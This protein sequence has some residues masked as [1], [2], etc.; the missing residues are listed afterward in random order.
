MR[1]AA[2]DSLVASADLNL[3]LLRHLVRYLTDHYTAREVEAIAEAAGI[4]VADLVSGSAWVSLDQFETVLACARGL[5]ANDATFT[6]ACAYGLD[7]V[8]S[9]IRLLLSA[10]S[11][12]SA[13]LAAG[14]NMGLISQISVFEPEVMSRNRVRIGYRTT[15]HES[16]LMCL[17]RQAQIRGLPTL[18][19]LPPAHVVETACVARGDDCCAY[20]V[21][22]Y[23]GRCWTPLAI[24]TALALAFGAVLD[25]VLSAPIQWWWV[26]LFGVVLGHFYELRRTSAANRRIQAEISSACLEIAL[27]E[28]NARRE[29]FT[30]ARRQRMWGDLVQEDVIGRKDALLRLTDELSELG[31]K[32][33]PSQP[34]ARIRSQVNKLRESGLAGQEEGR[35]SLSV[36]DAGLDEL[37]RRLTRAARLATHASGGS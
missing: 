12:V 14:R 27:A 11:P 37:D 19:A 2:K 10:V 28:A 33:D 34:T 3:R 29:L 24:G 7:R 31:R 13:Y 15:K 5:M 30:V 6:N 8:S 25:F 18:W 22:L 9:P 32:R 17:S 26:G 16:R 23:E 35:S 21:R 20:D 1:P 36:I 4:P